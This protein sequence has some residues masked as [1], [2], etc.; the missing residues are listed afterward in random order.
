[1]T[2][3]FGGGRICGLEIPLRGAV[4]LLALLGGEG[5]LLGPLSMESGKG[6]FRSALFLRCHA[7][8]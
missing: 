8:C 2:G 7:W 5:G 1:M 6:L 4:L 3:R